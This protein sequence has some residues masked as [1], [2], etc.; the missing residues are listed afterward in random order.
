MFLGVVTLTESH[1]A[2]QIYTYSTMAGE[3]R[4]DRFTGRIAWAGSKNTLD[5]QDGSL[6]LLNVTF[7]DTG[8]YHCYFNRVL[9]FTYYAY[10]TNASKFITINVVAKGENKA[11]SALARTATFSRTCL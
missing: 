10:H 8:T 3:V 6:Y 7:N 11:T 2:L 5:L 9:S 1:F 4:D